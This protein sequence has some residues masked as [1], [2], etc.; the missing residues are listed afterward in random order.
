MLYLSRS[1]GLI[2]A[3]FILPLAA[4]ASLPSDSPT[5]EGGWKLYQSGDFNVAETAGT[6]GNGSLFRLM[7][8]NVST[9]E[10]Y[11]SLLPAS[12]CS[13]G[14]SASIQFTTAGQPSVI[15]QQNCNSQNFV[16]LS[17]KI[18]DMESFARISNYIQKETK[19]TVQLVF[20]DEIDSINFD[21]AGGQ[22]V[23]Q[24]MIPNLTSPIKDFNDWEAV[25]TV[26]DRAAISKTTPSTVRKLSLGCRNGSKRD[27]YITYYSHMYPCVDGDRRKASYFIKGD[28]TQVND[29][30]SFTCKEAKW[31]ETDFKYIKRFVQ[32]FNQYGY[33]KTTSLEIHLNNDDPFTDRYSTNGAAQA[34][35]DIFKPVN[36]FS[37]SD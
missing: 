8:D 32:N 1:K 33:P 18:E 28:T 23:L 10:C 36:N 14:Y 20:S 22:S 9:H 7:C 6:L 19:T 11:Y 15:S 37:I 35:N 12:K 3:S 13:S 5:Q 21:F 2:L 29:S 4:N 25:T 27:C 24:Q 34:I 26:H 16:W 31:V 17:N 30:L